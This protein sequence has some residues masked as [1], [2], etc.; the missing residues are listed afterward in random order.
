M[1][2]EE[3]RRLESQRRWEWVVGLGEKKGVDWKR[4]RKKEKK[5]KK[6]IKLILF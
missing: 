6:K 2:G 1:E 4:R 3:L 5:E